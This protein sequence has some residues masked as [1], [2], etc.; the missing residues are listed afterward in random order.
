MEDDSICKIPC[1]VRIFHS[2]VQ[3]GD[4]GCSTLSILVVLYCGSCPR[5]SVFDND[6]RFNRTYCIGAKYPQALACYK[7]EI[8]GAIYFEDVLDFF[9]QGL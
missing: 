8:G 6:I 9:P 2:L 5:V 7:G 3:T 4:Y 1:R